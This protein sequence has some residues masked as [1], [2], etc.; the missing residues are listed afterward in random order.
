MSFLFTVLYYPLCLFQFSILEARDS[1]LLIAAFGFLHGKS[2]N[3]H[4]YSHANY[5][6][7][8]YIY[9]YMEYVS[10]SSKSVIVFFPH[11]VSMAGRNTETLLSY[12][13]LTGKVFSCLAF[14]PQICDIHCF[15]LMLTVLLRL[16]VRSFD[17][18]SCG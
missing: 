2:T 7:S 6:L 16:I 12:V 3:F 9:M 10:T 4:T 8:L 11:K 18:Q 1:N 15:I 13:C 17:Y 14:S 5:T